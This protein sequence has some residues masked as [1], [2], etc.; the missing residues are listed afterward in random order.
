MPADGE[1]FIYPG[2][3]TFI[4]AFGSHGSVENQGERVTRSCLKVL[5]EAKAYIVTFIKQFVLR[6]AYFL[7][8]RTKESVVSVETVFRKEW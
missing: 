3:S 5:D 4:A 8:C 6:S 7:C 2:I 1:V